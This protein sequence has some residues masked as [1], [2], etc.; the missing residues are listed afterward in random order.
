MP[1]LRIRS[2]NLNYRAI[3]DGVTLIPVY[4]YQA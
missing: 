3:I 1:H 2:H 4:N